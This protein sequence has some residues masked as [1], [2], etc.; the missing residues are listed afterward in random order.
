[1]TE[2]KR[3]KRG[4]GSIYDYLDGRG[5]RAQIR[6]KDAA[7][8]DVTYGEIFDTAEEAE[9][10]IVRVKAEHHGGPRHA[11][12][13]Q[14]TADLSR[15]REI[16]PGSPA[17]FA[18]F[19]SIW[20]QYK[21]SAVKGPMDPHMKTISDYEAN[22]R[23]YMIPKLGTI[24]MGRLHWDNIQPW[25]NWLRTVPSEMTG[26]PL[27][28]SAQRRIWTVFKQMMKYATAE[29]FVPR[30]PI[31]AHK[32]IEMPPQKV[33]K[34][35]M[36][37]PDFYKF[38]DYIRLRGCD[39][40]NDYCELR[41]ELAITLARRQ[42]EVLGLTYSDVTLTDHEQWL[43][44]NHHLVVRPYMHGCQDMNGQPTCH[45]RYGGHCP[46]RHSGGPILVSGTKAG[47]ASTPMIPLTPEIIRIFKRHRSLHKKELTELRN[48]GKLR[49]DLREM[50]LDDLVFTRP[51]N[52]NIWTPSDDYQVF[53]KL[54]QEAKVSRDYRLHD[55]RHSAVSNLV[56]GSKSL[57]T[58]Q[59]IAGHKT[60][61][62]TMKYV[63]VDLATLL[64]DLNTSNRALEQ[65]K[66]KSAAKKKR[67]AKK[68]EEAEVEAG[69]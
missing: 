26:R 14:D 35:A 6:L 54:L 67:K 10:W 56:A 25:I 18:E 2:G 43:E 55:L 57:S 31:G 62:T 60:I 45:R 48:A 15:P 27:S 50:S 61:L 24:K 46:K 13:P 63:D 17:T 44:V 19:A 41:W 64:A 22:I 68:K 65:G 5:V 20:M 3:R 69:E 11:L 23:L 37:K 8:R 7:G 34:R 66:S 4:T 32:G 36:S 59:A 51:H 1:M 39:H 58:A 29:Q 52:G 47:E 40:G 49:D 38:Q 21:Y 30:N 28:K 12:V 16:F 53:K 42:S 9:A 33:L